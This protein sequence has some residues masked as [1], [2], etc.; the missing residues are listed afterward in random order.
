MLAQ[1]CESTKEKSNI[2]SLLLRVVTVVP[3][4]RLAIELLAEGSRETILS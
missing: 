4:V 3:E 2:K 1:A